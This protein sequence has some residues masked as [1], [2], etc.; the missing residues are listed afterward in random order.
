MS[1]LTTMPAPAAG[2]AARR[3]AT[4]A[5]S[6]WAIKAEFDALKRQC[7]ALTS[8]RDALRQLLAVDPDRA[9]GFS[10]MQSQLPATTVMEAC[11]DFARLLRRIAI[12]VDGS[13]AL[14]E[15]ERGCEID[16]EVILES[17]DLIG[18]QAASGAAI[19]QRVRDLSAPIVGGGGS[20]NA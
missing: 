1:T 12:L 9:L 6:D 7:E 3:R 4:A 5:P 17:L 13:T 19:A 20:P 8:E 14:L 16:R 2:R 11:D 18:G 10:P 15:N